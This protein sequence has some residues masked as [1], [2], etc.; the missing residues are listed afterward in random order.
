MIEDF[1]YTP[2]IMSYIYILIA[3]FSFFLYL[4]KRY[5]SFL[6]CYIALMTDLFMLDTIGS[7]IRGSDLCLC[8]NLAL[9][10]FASFRRK[11]EKNDDKPISKCVNIF[12]VFILFEFAYTIFIGADSAFNALKVIRIPLMFL[13]YYLFSIIPLIVYQRFLKIMLWITIIQGVL[14]L[15]QFVGINLIAGNFEED[16]FTFSYALNVPTLIYFYLLF[17]LESEYTKKIK[18]LL[19]IFFLVILLL[20][21]VRAKIISIL[22]CITI[23]V[24]RRGLKKTI[25][26]ILLVLLVSPI[27]IMILDVKST[28]SKSGMSTKEEIALILSGPDNVKEQVKYGGTSVFRMGMLIERFDYLMQNPQYMLFGVGA[29][30]EDSPKCYNRFN[31]QLGTQNEDRYYGRCMIESGDITW[32]PII[33][34]YGIVGVVMHLSII[35]VIAIFSFKRKDILGILFPLMI[36]YFVSSFNGALFDRVTPFVVF[37][38]Y[39]SLLAKCEVERKELRI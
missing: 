6:L 32:V 21:F 23:Y 22:L 14:F 35:L 4:D 31:F 28:A 3:L 17:V 33:L 20:T 37:S 26:I 5:L 25:T 9:F 24:L 29:I 12:V 18:Y 34:R 30:H 19:F 16:N 7:A 13:V 8:I 11:K 39:L 1:F 27:A 10:P 2:Q 38:L 36:Y 15:L